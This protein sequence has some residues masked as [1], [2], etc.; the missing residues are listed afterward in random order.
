MKMSVDTEY[1]FY[2]CFCTILGLNKNKVESL[3]KFE[4]FCLLQGYEWR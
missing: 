2:R 1:V 3:N 4:N